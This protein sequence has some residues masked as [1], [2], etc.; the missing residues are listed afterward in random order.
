MPKSDFTYCHGLHCP[1][2]KQC[3][4]YVDGLAAAN[5]GNIHSWIK[6]CRHSKMFIHKDGVDSQD[7]CM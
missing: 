5:D 4:R 1:S 7:G 2:R 6:N 3:K